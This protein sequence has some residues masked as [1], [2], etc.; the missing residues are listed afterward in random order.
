MK[1]KN[2]NGRTAKKKSA[3]AKLKNHQEEKCSSRETPGDAAAEKCSSSRE[4]PRRAHLNEDCS[5]SRGHKRSHFIKVDDEPLLA[6]N[7]GEVADSANLV[8]CCDGILCIESRC[9]GCHSEVS[10]SLWNPALHQFKILPTTVH[11]SVFAIA[12]G[13]GFDDSC[14]DHK[15]VKVYSTTKSEGKKKKQLYSNVDVYSLRD[16]CWKTINTELITI[17]CPLNRPPLATGLIHNKCFYWTHG[18]RSIGNSHI[19]EG[20]TLENEPIIVY[21]VDLTNG[22]RVALELPNYVTIRHG[23]QLSGFRGFLSV[24]GWE[25]AELKIQELKMWSM[26]EDF[27]HGGYKWVRQ[28]FV[29]PTFL[30]ND[31]FV[32]NTNSKMLLAYKQG[33]RTN[34]V[35]YD[36]V[37]GTIDVLPAAGG[38]SVTCPGSLPESS[39][40]YFVAYNYIK[41]SVS[42]VPR[43]KPKHLKGLAKRVFTCFARECLVAS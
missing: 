19:Y 7:Q 38:G 20:K 11:R 3:T 21:K 16:G 30:Y 33:G 8:G 9:I 41:S 40:Q 26:V 14:N 15:V 1:T 28:L 43:W 27:I 24:S 37:T 12:R 18:R 39:A 42:V 31:K 22:S 17:S 29:V 4:T 10:I 36:F 6:S 32:I 23:Y 35:V 13:F 34:L 2:N 5:S 25:N